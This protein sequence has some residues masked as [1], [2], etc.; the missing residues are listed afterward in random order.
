MHTAGATKFLISQ[1]PKII[2]L[3][4][5]IFL[6]NVWLYSVVDYVSD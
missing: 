4:L 6:Q 2:G 3:E 5:F 1:P